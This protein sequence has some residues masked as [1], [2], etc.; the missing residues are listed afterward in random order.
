MNPE[1]PTDPRKA[2]ESSLTAL[3]LGELPDDQARF[4][5]QAIATDPELA[6]TFDTL[7][8]FLLGSV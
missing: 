1:L 3:L 7:Q 4:L 8:R 6:Q 2:L 5:R